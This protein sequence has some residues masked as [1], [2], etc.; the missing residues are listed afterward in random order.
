MAWDFCRWL[1]ACIFHPLPQHIVNKR[2]LHVAVSSVAVGQCRCVLH[3][4]ALVPPIRS[5]SAASGALRYAKLVNAIY[6]RYIFPR[7]LIW[8]TIKGRAAFVILLL[9]FCLIANLLSMT[10]KRK[11]KGWKWWPRSSGVK[12][13]G[14][15]MVNSAPVSYSRYWHNFLYVLLL[16]YYCYNVS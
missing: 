13:E 7:K 14:T 16:N 11:S 2:N 8:R 9:N 10:V 3:L 6:I 12:H 1:L 15:P 5:S 4:W